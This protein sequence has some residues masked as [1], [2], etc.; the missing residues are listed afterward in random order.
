MWLIDPTE[1]R[2]VYG[3]WVLGPD[4][5]AGLRELNRVGVSVSDRPSMVEA[6]P[7]RPARRA[8]EIARVVGIL[9]GASALWAWVTAVDTWGQMP[10]WP[11]LPCLLTLLAGLAFGM[12]WWFDRRASQVVADPRNAQVNALLKVL[13]VARVRAPSAAVIE[14]AALV[15]AAWQEFTATAGY[16]QATP[17]EQHAWQLRVD[18]L[19]YALALSQPSGSRPGR[20]ELRGWIH[21]NT[22]RMLFDLAQG[23]GK[24]TPEPAP[25]PVAPEEQTLTHYP[26]YPG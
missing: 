26:R 23:S 7:H 6:L 4:G 9:V 21:R 3:R 15:R 11:W 13:D 2:L 17:A 8:S 12:F 5:L 25:D 19:L 14:V 20:P 18:R 16:T 10:G 24:P 22:Q 1:D